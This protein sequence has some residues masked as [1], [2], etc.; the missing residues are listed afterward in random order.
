[1]NRHKLGRAKLKSSSRKCVND[2]CSGGKRRVCGLEN[3]VLRKIAPEKP[4]MQRYNRVCHS[5]N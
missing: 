3:V 2:Y 4:L 1:M 5:E